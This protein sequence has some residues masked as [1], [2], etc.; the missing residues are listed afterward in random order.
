MNRRNFFKVVTGFV[1]GIFAVP[2]A[3]AKVSDEKIDLTREMYANS[4]NDMERDADKLSS[5]IIQ[6]NAELDGKIKLELRLGCKEL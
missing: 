1:A 4:I 3:K 5:E 2:K 6:A